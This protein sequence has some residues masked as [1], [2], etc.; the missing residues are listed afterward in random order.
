[1]VFSRCN[2]DGSWFVL[3]ILWYY[4]IMLIMIFCHASSWFGQWQSGAGL[5]VSM[6]ADDPN[7]GSIDRFIV[8]LFFSTSS[9]VFC[10][11]DKSFEVLPKISE[12]QMCVV[13]MSHE[14][15]QSDSKMTQ[16]WSQYD[17]MMTPTWS[18]DDSKTNPKWSQ[19]DSKMI[20]QWHQ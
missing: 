13:E 11:I 4:A 3:S 18:Q 19:I 10:L 16:Q 7:C 14:W 15:S 5:A 12:T 8:A 2:M 1:M 9:A 20:I 17:H 6:T